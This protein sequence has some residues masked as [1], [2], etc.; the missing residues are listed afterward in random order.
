LSGCFAD[1]SS[2]FNE[3]VQRG[4]VDGVGVT[5]G[6]VSSSKLQWWLPGDGFGDSAA[7]EKSWASA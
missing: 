5:A 7:V 1:G 2:V 6:R 4:D 3:M